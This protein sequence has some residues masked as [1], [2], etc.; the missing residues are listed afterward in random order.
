MSARAKADMRRAS[1]DFLESHVLGMA[2]SPEIEPRRVRERPE[3]NGETEYDKKAPAI[4]GASWLRESEGC[5]LLLRLGLRRWRSWCRFLAVQLPNRKRLNLPRRDLRLGLVFPFANLLL[6][7][8]AH[9]RSH[10]IQ[11]IALLQFLRRVLRETIPYDD[12]MPLGFFSSFLV[13][14]RP[15]GL[16]GQREGR[17]RPPRVFCGFAFRG[18]P[19]KAHK[20]DSIFVHFLSLHFCPCNWGT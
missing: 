15:P 11:M 5:L 16:G 7:D 19:Q 17:E 6:I 13:L 14:T 2:D 12:A 1:L 18:L 4:A 20:F 10:D 3:K 8:V 9:E